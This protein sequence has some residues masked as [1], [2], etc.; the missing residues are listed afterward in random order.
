[1][2]FVFKSPGCTG[3][4]GAFVSGVALVVVCAGGARADVV[5][6][7]DTDAFGNPITVPC[8]F[9]ETT[10]LRDLYAPLGVT[11][12]GPAP[13]DGGA[14]ID[15][16]GNFNFSPLSGD[17]FL[18]FN[19]NATLQDGG[20]PTG[21]QTLIFC[22]AASAVSIWAVG[23]SGSFFMQAFDVND[24]QLTSDFAANVLGYSHLSVSAPG[25]KRVVLD[26]QFD[27]Q[28]SWA[29]DDLEFR[30]CQWD[31]EQTPNGDVDL[32]DFLTLIGDWGSQGDC[33]FDGGGVG[34][35]DLLALL[36]NWGPCP[37][38]CQ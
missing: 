24:V 1:M 23:G 31:C 29:Y 18:V 10:A 30:F 35:N 12:A 11:F 33:D 16:C 9:A 19:P 5:I 21:P 14:H 22:P 6:N 20:T 27:P 3:T 4:R 7:F 28:I 2:L 32:I 37:Y 36:S 13:N 38:N 15:T 26:A 25:I 34:I 17:N 8:A